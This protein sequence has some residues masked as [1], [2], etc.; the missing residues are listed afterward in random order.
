MD[1]LVVPSILDEAFGMVAAEFA[2]M[3]EPAADHVCFPLRQT[4]RP[5]LQ[6]WPPSRPSMGPHPRFP[7]G[8]GFVA[9]TH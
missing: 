8:R 7:A 4:I 5:T 3:G 1:V 6:G 9:R 2:E